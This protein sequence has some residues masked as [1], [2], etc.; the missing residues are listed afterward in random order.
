MPGWGSVKGS[1]IRPQGVFPR[2]DRRA[3]HFAPGSSPFRRR[4]SLFQRGS[5]LF[6]RRNPLSGRKAAISKAERPI[7]RSETGL[8]G[9]E[10][11]LP[12]EN[13]GFC[14][15]NSCFYGGSSVFSNGIPVFRA[16]QATAAEEFRVC[17]V[18]AR[19]QSMPRAA[20]P[21]KARAEVTASVAPVAMK[22]NGHCDAD[23]GRVSSA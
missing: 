18:E 8:F 3:F 23:L 5:S 20:S 6:R 10:T 13:L 21:V 16:G 1:P 17:G 4:I 14:R 9:A 2:N 22:R 19:S 15:G 12:A 11:R 7:F